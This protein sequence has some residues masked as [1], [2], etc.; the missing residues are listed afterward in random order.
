MGETDID[1]TCC[2]FLG[3]AQP[4][5]ASLAM[6]VA[7]L[8]KPQ[9]QKQ[10]DSIFQGGTRRMMSTVERMPNTAKAESGF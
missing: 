7:L 9:P 6:L 10:Q 3:Q 2:C 1:R 5:V 4:V 8:L